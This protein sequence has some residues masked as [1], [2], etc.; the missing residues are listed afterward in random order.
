MLFCDI[1][2][3]WVTLGAV[4]EMYAT[5]SDVTGFFGRVARVN[6]WERALDFR[7][8]IPKMVSNFITF[9]SPF[10]RRFRKFGSSTKRTNLH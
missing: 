4:D 6:A 1:S 10:K 5:Y 2:S 7:I 8:E 3:G 9:L